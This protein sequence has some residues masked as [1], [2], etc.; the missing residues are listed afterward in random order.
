M[1]YEQKV[2]TMQAVVSQA[3]AATRATWRETFKILLLGF[4]L[5]QLALN[6]YFDL[7]DHGPVMALRDLAGAVAMRRDAVSFQALLKP[8]LD[9]AAQLGSALFV[10]LV[11]TIVS[12]LALVHVYVHYAQTG[13]HLSFGQALLRGVRS[14]LPKGL[15]LF[16]IAVFFAGSLGQIAS[17]P[18][19]LLVILACMIPVILVV[20]KRGAFWTLRAAVT[21]QYA[22]QS[23]YSGWN[24]FFT[25]VTLIAFLYT[26]VAVAAFGGQ[27]LMILDQTA[28]IPRNLWLWTFPGLSFG[29]FYV[30]LLLIETL[31][32]TITVGMAPALTAA[33]YFIVVPKRELG[34]A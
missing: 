27:E 28:G 25:L 4:I 26:L 18:V 3:L 6:L 15:F 32:T 8:A 34:Q 29:P 13:A 5:P 12:Y 7:T 20:E 21:I 30:L 10:T 22:R 17:A 19:I 1:T 33:L 24:V 31:V 23:P 9:Y 11:W 2:L 14:A 16:F